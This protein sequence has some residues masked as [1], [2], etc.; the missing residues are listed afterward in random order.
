MIEELRHIRRRQAALRATIDVE[1]NFF[2]WQESCVPSYCH[3][4]PLI[5]YVSWQRLFT[6]AKLV[7]RH[8]RRNP[9]VLDFGASVGEMVHLLDNVQA[10]DFVE[11]DESATS[12]FLTQYPGAFRQTFETALRGNYDVVLAMDAL[13]HNNNY[14]EIRLIPLPP[15]LQDVGD[16]GA[17]S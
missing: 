2:Q 10:Y 9:R 13:E 6:A 11:K 14:S 1:S 5:A 15:G 7:R 4:N 17:G 3:R 16:T 8:A 12:I